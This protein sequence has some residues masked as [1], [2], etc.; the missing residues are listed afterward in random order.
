MNLQAFDLGD[1]AHIATAA[2]LWTAA[3]GPDLAISDR[4][5]AYNVRSTSGRV[6][7]GQFVMRDGQPAGFVLASALVGDLLAASPETGHIDAIAVLPQAQR[8]GAGSA[9]L[10]W[11]EDWLYR[12]G[13]NCFVLGASQRPFVPGVPDALATA[14]FFQR[15][16][17]LPNPGYGWSVDMAH[18]LR[19]Y[20]TPPAALKAQGVIVRPAQPGD[21]EAMLAFLRREFPGGWRYECEEFLRAGGRISDYVLLYSERDSGRSVDGCCLVTFEDSLRPLDRF[22]PFQLPRPWGQLGAIGVSADRRGEGYGAALL[23]GGLRHLRDHGVRGCIIDW[24]VL[25]D[26]YAKFGFRVHRHYTMMSKRV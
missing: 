7:A 10:G 18:D 23:D 15:R 17:Y 24:L 14:P 21:E 8:Q 3:C 19:D 5:V 22:Y 1:A 16:G 6:L 20:V 26:F 13:C 2:R 12:L 4:F 25:V 11:A 9:L